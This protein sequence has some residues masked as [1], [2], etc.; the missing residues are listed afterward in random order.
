MDRHILIKCPRTGMHVQHWLEDEPNEPEGVYRQI[1]CPACVQLHFVNPKTGKLLG[2][3]IG[4]SPAQ[5]SI[6]ILT[7]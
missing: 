1:T 4:T 2:E 3:R 6:T 7:S 5:M